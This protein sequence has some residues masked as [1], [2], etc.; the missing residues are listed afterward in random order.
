ME[1]WQIIIN[2]TCYLLSVSLSIIVPII[3]K[4]NSIEDELREISK[5]LERQKTELNEKILKITS[6]IGCDRTR[7]LAEQIYELKKLLEEVNEK[8]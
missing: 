5:Q 8:L 2:M 7:S 6:D 4:L 1:W 3:L